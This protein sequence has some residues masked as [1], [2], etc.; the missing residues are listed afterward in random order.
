MRA[1]RR[2]F[3]DVFEILNLVTPCVIKHDAAGNPVRR[4][5]R[6]TAADARSRTNSKFAAETYSG[7]H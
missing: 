6:I 5:F 7:G 3:P 1:A 4:K 2:D